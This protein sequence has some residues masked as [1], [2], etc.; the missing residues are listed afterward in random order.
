LEREGLEGWIGEIGEEGF[1]S[2]GLCFSITKE[3]FRF[4]SAT[5]SCN[6]ELRGAVTL[7]R[8]FSQTRISIDFLCIYVIRRGVP[9]LGWTFLC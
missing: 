7:Q 4:H 1:E 8:I 5:C 9:K 3:T 2:I 6:A